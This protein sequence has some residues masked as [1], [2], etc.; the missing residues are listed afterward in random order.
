MGGGNG[1]ARMFRNATS[2]NQDISSWDISNANSLN[3]M[4]DGATA[5]QQ[6]I[7]SWD[8]S[9]ITGPQWA[10]MSNKQYPTANY[11]NLLMGWSSQ[12][13]QNGVYIGFG[14]SKY[15]A[16]A[17]ASARQTLINKGWTILDGGQ[18]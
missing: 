15:S 12:N 9:N 11:D 2:F 16:G 4:F 13:V 6:N 10:F 1:F 5:F 14:T 3:Y 17:A 7:G 18:A 8:V